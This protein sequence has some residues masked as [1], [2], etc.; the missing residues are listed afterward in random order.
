[1]AEVITVSALNQY[2]KTLLDA[3]DILFDLAL[4][5]EIANFVQNARS[6]HC[7]FSLRDASASVKAVMFRS[8]ARRLGFRPEEGMKVVVR[9][10]ATLYERDGAFQIYVNEMFP[11]GIGAAQLAFEQLKAK[12]EQEGLFAAEHKKPLPAYPKCIGV[13]TSKTGAALQDIRNVIG[14]RWPAAKLLLC[15]VNVQG[16]EAAE[17]I[18]D[19]ITRLEI[20]EI[21]VLAM[22][23]SRTSQDPSPFADSDAEAALIL[24]DHGIFEGSASGDQILFQPQDDISR[25]EITTVIWR[26]YHYTPPESPETPPTS[27]EDPDAPEEEGDYFYFGNKKVYVV[28]EMPKRTYDSSLFQVNENGFLTYNSD[29]YDYRI[30]IDVSRYQGEIDWA[31]VK[32]AGVDFAMIRLGYRGYGTGRIVTDTYFETNLKGALENDIEVGVYF[33][34]QAINEEE[35]MEEAQYCM[36]LLQDYDITYPIVFDWEPYDSS[37]NPRTD[38]LSDEM[39]TK[40]AVAFCQAVEDGGYE[41]MVYSNLTYFYLHYDLAQL[42]DFPLWLAQYNETP[43]FYYH[44][45]MWQY[46]STGT[47]PG[48][49][50]NVDL[51]IQLIPKA[52]VSYKNCPTQIGWG[53][54]QLPLFGSLIKPGKIREIGQVEVARGLQRFLV[55]VRVCH[56]GH[57]V[58]RLI[59]RLSSVHGI[60]KNPGVCQGRSHGRPGRVEDG[61]GALVHPQIP[62]GEHFVQQR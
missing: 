49:E 33:F 8:D 2:V 4:R 14:R 23:L 25:A 60:L 32:D 56:T 19:A 57:A 10:R 51:N 52:T 6:G 1:M 24:W 58:A 13:V 3:N 45:S 37:L 31:A 16:F 41:S 40:C 12:L 55:A 46:S 62:T 27:P 54:F 11:D 17:E 15:P 34:S 7:Y 38:G 35:A 22:D 50:G 53:N 21:T 48:I 29:D 5:G 30:G 59:G 26:I 28:E 36:D 39:L 42:V 61:G 9:C 43:T 20:A 18:A 44:F 47:V